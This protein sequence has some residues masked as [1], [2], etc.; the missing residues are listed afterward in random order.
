[1]SRWLILFIYSSLH[2]GNSR[3]YRRR[4]CRCWWIW[5]GVQTWLRSPS[6]RTSENGEIVCHFR[7][8]HYCERSREHRENSVNIC[9]LPWLSLSSLRWHVAWG[10]RSQSDDLS[11]CHYV[12]VLCS[13]MS[14]MHV[15][16]RNREIAHKLC[17]T[18]LRFFRQHQMFP[19][20]VIN[21][22]LMVLSL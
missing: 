19:K 20:I 1:M 8:L 2:A 12:A 4:R 10:L 5:S 13:F 11:L 22:H 15:G 7:K 6:Q 16:K 14:V 17:K 21:A 18:L 3:F 9:T